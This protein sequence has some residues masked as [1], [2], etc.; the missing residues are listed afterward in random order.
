MHLSFDHLRESNA[1]PMERIR[2]GELD[3]AI[4]RPAVFDGFHLCLPALARVGNNIIIDHIIE[5]ERWMSDLLR[6]LSP[7]EVFFVGVHC[8]LPELERRERQRADR[9]SSS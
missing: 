7:Y 4:M 3:W 2:S 5:N 8:P 9:R 1:L 6:L